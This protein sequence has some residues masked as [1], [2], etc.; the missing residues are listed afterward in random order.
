MT[1]RDYVRASAFASVAQLFPPLIRDELMADPGLNEKFGINKDVVFTFATSGEVFQRAALITAVRQASHSPGREIKVKDILGSE[2]G[3]IV[4]S[5][6]GSPNVTVK[7]PKRVLHFGELTMIAEGAQI[8]ETALSAY[9]DSVNLPEDAV[10]KWRRIIRDRPLDFDE[11]FE[12]GNDLECTPLAVS[13]SISEALIQ[14]NIPI[15][16]MVP[17]SLEYYERLVGRVSSQPSIKEYAQEVAQSFAEGL[18]KWRPLEGFKYALLLGSH[19][20]IA[21]VL[22]SLPLEPGDFKKLIEWVTER[23]DILSRGAALELAF[24]RP[25]ERDL[26]IDVLAP[27]VTSYVDEAHGNSL[28]FELYS[29]AFVMVYGELAKTGVIA[30]KPVYWQR[31]GAMAQAALLTRCVLS[32][33]THIRK[34]IEWFR[35]I[36]SSEYVIRCHVDRKTDPMWAPQFALLPQLKN[37][38]AGRVFASAM[39]NQDVTENL[40][41]REKLTGDDETS[42]KSQLTLPLI[43]LSGPLE[44]NLAPVRELPAELLEVIRKEITTKSPTVESF[45]GLI[46]AVQQAKVSPE[47]PQMAAEALRR[48]H[49]TL[50]AAEGEDSLA[51]C[52][53]GLAV[54]A[55]ITRNVELAEAVF[56]AVRIS[57]RKRDR[58]LSIVQ[59]FEIGLV[60]CASHSAL[61]EWHQAVGTFMTDLCFNELQR[62]EATELHELFA[63]LCNMVPQLWGSCAPALAA[64]EA[65]ASQ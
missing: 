63:S 52:L 25:R 17:R 14:G 45:M 50:D 40:E 2:W 8:R 20:L 48:S 47:F 46:S 28:A 23:G 7:S 12:F 16:T 43:L 19:S 53:M 57:R 1:R 61:L 26:M 56:I 39:T 58:Q 4:S 54:V 36:R 11:F 62:E 60:A 24:V 10:S 64:V 6:K 30:T 49:Y 65:V 21:K 32:S 34:S 33:Q 31:L 35:N 51:G 38:L 59:A 22:G 15:A 13:Q 5:E 9:A 3:V 37:E 55:A 44:G 41:L 42:L 27:L 29:S 18:F